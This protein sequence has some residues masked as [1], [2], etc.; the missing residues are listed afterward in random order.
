MVAY[1]QSIQIWA[2]RIGTGVGIVSRREAYRQPVREQADLVIM[3][4]RGHGSLHC[5]NL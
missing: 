4:V 1:S 3:G 5:G 2:I